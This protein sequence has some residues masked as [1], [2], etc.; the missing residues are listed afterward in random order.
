MR[1]ANYCREFHDS[2]GYVGFEN[3]EEEWQKETI[4]QVIPVIYNQDLPS[5]AFDNFF[6]A[7]SDKNDFENVLKRGCCANYNG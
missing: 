1:Q 5:I 2:H 7:C 6:E 4:N 3:I